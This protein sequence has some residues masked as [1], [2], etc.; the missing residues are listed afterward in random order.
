MN[1]R[2]CDPTGA[3]FGWR[4]QPKRPALS[5]EPTGKIIDVSCR[6]NDMITQPIEKLVC[7]P[8]GCLPCAE[9]RA[10]F[11]A[12]AFGP[13]SALWALPALE[14]RRNAGFLARGFQMWC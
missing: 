8:D 13:T 5:L 4:L 3:I 1:R 2:A 11:S 6:G 12:V 10:N 14:K 7:V 9:M